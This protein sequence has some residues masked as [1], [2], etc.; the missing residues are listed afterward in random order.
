MQQFYE[1]RLPRQ[2][3]SSDMDFEE[4]R[5]LLTEERIARGWSREQAARKVSACMARRAEEIA[6]REVGLPEGER[7]KVRD[8]ITGQ[9]LN[10]WEMKRS[11]PSFEDLASWAE[12]MGF[13]TV[14]EVTRSA[15]GAAGQQVKAAVGRLEGPDLEALLLFARLLEASDGP[16]HQMLREY[17]QMMA[18]SIGAP[19]GG[20]R[21]AG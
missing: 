15:G 19:R 6:A 13:A 8:S 1:N 7:T 10:N 18:R 12:A 16:A 5:T 11:R 9:G 4:I 20:K 21:S 14:M 3:Y 17:P 2:R